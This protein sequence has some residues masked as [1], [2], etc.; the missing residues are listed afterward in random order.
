[1]ARKSLDQQKLTLRKLSAFT[2]LVEI[3]QMVKNAAMLMEIKT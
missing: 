2:G 3:V 1:M